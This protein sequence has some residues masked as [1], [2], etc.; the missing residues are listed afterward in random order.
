VLG[1]LIAK[2]YYDYWLCRPFCRLLG[3]IAVRRDGHDVAATRGA[4]R[5]LEQGRVVPIFPEGKIL[6]TSGRELGPGR[7]GT[8]FI[9]LKARMPVIP[10]Y[11][12]GTPLSDDPFV[13]LRRPSRSR[14]VYGPPIEIDFGSFPDPG[15]KAAITEV[16]H[17]LMG[18][19]EALR[20]RVLAEAGQPAPVP[21]ERLHSHARP[22]DAAPGTVSGQFT[23]VHTA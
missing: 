14:V 13:S 11:I 4:L 18:A 23:A 21:S 8:A 7:P 16:T 12:S 20:A 22:L 10:A 5:A 1:F 15:D 2:E 3:C 17:R 9:A 6:A 19:I